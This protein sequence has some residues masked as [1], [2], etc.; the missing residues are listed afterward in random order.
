MKKLI[1]RMLI[2]LFGLSGLG[3]VY[4]Q[5]SKRGDFGHSPVEILD[6]VVADA[7]DDRAYSVQDTQLD[8]VD[9]WP[10]RYRIY[11]TLQWIRKNISPYLQWAVY[12]WLTAA[13]ILLIFNGLR[14]VTT[15]L[16]DSGKIEQ[17]KKNIVNIVIWVL[18]LTGFYI[19]FKLIIALINAVF[20]Q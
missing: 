14:M 20:A 7:N 5:K 16:H 2:G 1:V 11:N 18:L 13:V 3:F 19:I 17:I 10:G 9:A 8:G 6:E 4:A 12:I 15:G